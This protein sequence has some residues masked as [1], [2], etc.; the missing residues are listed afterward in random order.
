MR[1]YVWLLAIV[2]V[3]GVIYPPAAAAIACAATTAAVAVWVLACLAS[4]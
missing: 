4:R 1:A 2:F 3:I